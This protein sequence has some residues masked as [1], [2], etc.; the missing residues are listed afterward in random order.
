MSYYLRLK[1]CVEYENMRIMSYLGSLTVDYLKKAIIKVNSQDKELGMR[2]RRRERM[3]VIVVVVK[4][5]TLFWCCG[6][7]DF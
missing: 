1:Q 2:E 5:N 4:G 3:G 6:C 7:G